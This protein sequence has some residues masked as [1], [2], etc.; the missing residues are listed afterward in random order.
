MSGPRSETGEWLIKRNCSAGPGQL[1]IVF[2]SMV[3][4]SFV[5]GLGFA[6]FG[7]WMVLPFVGL[8]LIA[9]GAAFLCYGR[10]AADF[11]RIAV[12]PSMLSVEQVDGAHSK[13]WQFDPRV[14][15]VETETRGRFW[16]KRVR[17]HLLGPEI[18][19]ELGRYLLD[20]RRTQFARELEGTLMRA[21][22]AAH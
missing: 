21:R 18:K 1:A 5:F 22:A 9:V 7:L 17:I 13:R 15:R 19:L 8:E 2:G 14:A 11:E 12:S 6:A 4:V 3:A 20:R 16:G 10:H